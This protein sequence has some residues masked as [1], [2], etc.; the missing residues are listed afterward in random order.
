[1]IK[2]SRLR[3]FGH[4]ERK[5]D[6]D[7]VRHGMILDVEGITQRGRL[8][9]SWWDYVKNDMESL[10]LSREDMCFRNKWRRIKRQPDNSGSPGNLAVKWCGV[11]CNS[12]L[13]VTKV[14]Q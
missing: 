8:K 3:W 13:G 9:K 4:V 1:M 12:S 5:D 10:G 6:N 7:W 2:K 14:V 11:F